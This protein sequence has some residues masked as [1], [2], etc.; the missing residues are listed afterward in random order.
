MAAVLRSTTRTKTEPTLWSMVFAGRTRTGCCKYCFILS[1]LEQHCELLLAQPQRDTQTKSSSI[2]SATKAF[3]AWQ[4]L[5]CN[6]WN[7]NPVLHCP[8]P[9]CL[10]VSAYTMFLELKNNRQRLQRH[11]KLPPLRNTAITFMGLS[12]FN[13]T[14]HAV[15][16]L[17]V[18]A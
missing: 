7:Y 1:Q 10:Y 13:F 11:S 5:I 12:I 9:R 16:N 18:A 15:T 8:I 3:Q 4:S 14:E 2:A 17:R 6:E